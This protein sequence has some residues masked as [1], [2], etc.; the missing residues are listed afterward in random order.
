VLCSVRDLPGLTRS[1]HFDPSWQPSIRGRYGIDHASSAAAE[2]NVRASVSGHGVESEGHPY[3]WAIH[4]K[5]IVA[6]WNGSGGSARRKRPKR[7]SLSSGC[8]TWI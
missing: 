1:C 3:I 2:R 6:L 5:E 8:I 4:E 7:G